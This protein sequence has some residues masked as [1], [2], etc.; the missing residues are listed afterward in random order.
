MLGDEFRRKV[1][2]LLHANYDNVREE[3]HFQ[4][5][6]AD[7][8]FTMPVP[9]RSNYTV[10][11]ECKD[12]DSPLTSSDLQKICWEYDAA[13]KSREIDLLWIIAP[14]NI[15]AMPRETIE[16]YRPQIEFMSFSEFEQLILIDFKPYLQ[17]LRSDFESDIVS[18]YYIHARTTDGK[19]LH[20]DVILPWSSDEGAPSI[21]IIAGY[22]M[23]KTSY[24]RFLAHYLSIAALNNYDSRIPIYLQLGNLTQHQSLRTLINTLF[25]DEFRLR[26]YNYHLFDQLNKAGRFLLICDGFDEM[27][28]AMKPRDIVENFRDIGKLRYPKTKLLL[29]GRPNPF[30]T[31]EDVA[32]IRGE[33]LIKGSFH[34][35]PEREK[36]DQ[37]TLD[38]F[39]EGE[40]HR[41]FQGFLTAYVQRNANKYKNPEKFL[42]ERL[43]ELSRI[44]VDDMVRRPV[45]AKMLGD[46]SIVE[47][48]PLESYNEYEL[49]K[50]FILKTI[51]RESEKSARKA[52]PENIRLEFM[53][54]V[55]WWLWT[56]KKQ[57]LFSPDEL[58]KELN[59]FVVDNC[60]D[61]GDV[62]SAVREFITGSIIENRGPLLLGSKKGVFFY[63]PHRSYL[64]FLVAEYLCS[65]LS[66]RQDIAAVGELMNA[67][68]AKFINLRKDITAIDQL[69][70]KMHGLRA[71]FSPIILDVVKRSTLVPDIGSSDTRFDAGDWWR[72]GAWLEKY[73]TSDNPDPVELRDILNRRSLKLSREHHAV[74]LCVLAIFS[75]KLR[76]WPSFLC[77]LIMSRLGTDSESTDLVPVRLGSDSRTFDL[78]SSL[79]GRVFSYDAVSLGLW[80][81]LDMVLSRVRSQLSDE[82][83]MLKPTDASSERQKVDVSTV[84]NLADSVAERR[85][86]QRLIDSFKPKN[87]RTPQPKR[88]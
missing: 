12:W 39:S 83:G 87:K 86:I 42:S 22:G 78:Y 67:E 8:S 76:N 34:T 48:Q 14:R 25:S 57:N 16:A 41:Y 85:E 88:R 74:L 61:Q 44:P 47:T 71:Q 10:A 37:I 19:K 33:R 45:H 26:G 30:Q 49:Y 56:V 31:E 38:F 55:A 81:N 65:D 62:Q 20:E 51:E 28:H 77:Y 23:G 54:K 50:N 5:K 24:A 84:L 68:I 4:G 82:I 40:L 69:L 21:A 43:A 36:Y 60:D 11:V 72:F 53:L 64:E 66:T 6:N 1:A 80:I 63:F 9:P 79:F 75:Y 15:G 27:K 17:A 52:I 59:D 29:L 46:L 35:D 7:I 73:L 18:Q 2:D 3:V 70:E 13:L 58:P 32:V